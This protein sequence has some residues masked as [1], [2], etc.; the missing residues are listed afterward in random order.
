MRLDDRAWR[1]AAV[2]RV[3]GT[4]GQPVRRHGAAMA[5]AGGGTITAGCFLSRFAKA[6]DWAH[7][8]IAGTAWISGGKDKGATG[9][10]CRC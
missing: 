5:E 4:T 1:I 10:R 3:P 7:L 2:R 9:R 6:Y 8:D